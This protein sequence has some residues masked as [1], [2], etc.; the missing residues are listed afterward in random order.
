MLL[1]WSWESLNIEGN[2]D[3]ATREQ[4]MQALGDYL[5]SLGIAP[6]NWEAAEFSAITK[7]TV[8]DYRK[9]VYEEAT[10][11]DNSDAEKDGSYYNQIKDI[12]AEDFYCFKIVTKPDGNIPLFSDAVI[13]VGKTDKNIAGQ[14]IDIV[15]TQN[16]FEFVYFSR[17]VE[18]DNSAAPEEVTLIGEEKAKDAFKESQDV[19]FDG[20]IAI[21]EID[22]IYLPIPQN[23]LNR[24]AEDFETRPFYVISFDKIEEYE[25]RTVT[26]D[27]KA[28]IDGVTGEK[29]TEQQWM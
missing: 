11:S 28:F 27:W 26:T 14:S 1:V 20:E 25:G 3:F 2:L 23:D 12:P 24:Y 4:A 19:L 6:G 10:N 22:L 21:K 15:Y 5:N 8:E 13:Q 16:G 29:L 7:A 9:S 18:L 17:I